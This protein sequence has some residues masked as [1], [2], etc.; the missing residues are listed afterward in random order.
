M[1]LGRKIFLWRAP[2]VAIAGQAA[3]QRVVLR[4]QLDVDAR[5]DF[6]DDAADAALAVSVDDC[7]AEQARAAERREAA[8][9]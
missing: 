4:E 3:L 7:A 8:T 9:A 2:G 6:R 5:R 1:A